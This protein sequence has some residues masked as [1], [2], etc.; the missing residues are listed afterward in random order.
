MFEDK[1]ANNRFIF[2]HFSPAFL[3]FP[4]QFL[5]ELASTIK[6]GDHSV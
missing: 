6:K 5:Y 2:S 1:N 3:L 4:D